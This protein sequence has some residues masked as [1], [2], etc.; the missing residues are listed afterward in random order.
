MKKIFYFMVAVIVMMTATSC[1]KESHVD[2]YDD[3]FYFL[4]L[5]EPA[6]GFVSARTETTVGENSETEF[7]VARNFYDS[8]LSVKVVVDKSLTTAEEGVDFTIDAK[9]FSFKGEEAMHLPMKVS[10][11]DNT[12]GKKIVMQLVYEYYNISPLEGRKY[13]TMTINIE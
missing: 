6:D 10:V 1:E 11:G 13:D 12:A 9:S 3:I 4:Q 8:D 2:V 7:L 5:D